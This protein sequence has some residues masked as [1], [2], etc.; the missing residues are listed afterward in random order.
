M[1][2][3]SRGSFKTKFA[4]LNNG[5]IKENEGKMSKISVK[6]AGKS[7]NKAG[8]PDYYSVRSPRS[9]F[10][11]GNLLLLIRI[12]TISFRGPHIWHDLPQDVKSSDSL[13]LLKRYGTLT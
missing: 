6:K 11:N 2:G 5:R 8:N 12:E 10:L 7:G 4:S 13:N 3:I 1:S 9:Q